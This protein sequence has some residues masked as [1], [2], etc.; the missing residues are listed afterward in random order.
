M[1]VA[2]C[3]GAVP[4]NGTQEP[5]TSAPTES[6]DV[7]IGKQKHP[8]YGRNRRN[9]YRYLPGRG[10]RVREYV[11]TQIMKE[12]QEAYAVEDAADDVEPAADHVAPATDDMAPAVEDATD[13]VTPG[14]EQAAEASD[15][16]AST[17]LPPDN[18]SGSNYCEGCMFEQEYKTSQA[19][20]VGGVGHVPTHTGAT[21]CKWHTP[22]TD[23]SA[24]QAM[25]VASAEEEASIAPVVAAEPTAG[26]TAGASA[27]G[28]AAIVAAESK[29]VPVITADTN[30]SGCNFTVEVKDLQ[31]TI[32]TIRIP[33]GPAWTGLTLRRVYCQINRV[34]LSSTDPSQFRL[35]SHF[36][37]RIIT[38]TMHLNSL[39]WSSHT[40]SRIS[41]M[42]VLSAQ[43]GD[44]DDDSTGGEDDDC[45]Y[46]QEELQD[47][48][49]AYMEDS[50]NFR[51]DSTN[52]ERWDG[53]VD[54]LA[55]KF[56]EVEP[57]ATARAS[58]CF[59]GLSSIVW[60]HLQTIFGMALCVKC[61]TPRSQP[62]S[63]LL[64]RDQRQRKGP[65][66]SWTGRTVPYST[67]SLA[68]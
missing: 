27:E 59:W 40:A 17:I 44:D 25:A 4:C 31:G 3:D 36:G 10:G 34:P 45:T 5:T 48:T 68:C 62:V 26:E 53:L 41:I 9:I 11:Y 57:G 2:G 16:D 54:A 33:C 50:T 30:P 39:R 14:V 24:A 13:D 64:E 19:L 21:G 15:S 42:R 51:S 46:S 22:V 37:G 52:S 49:R 1:F 20:C 18:D 60:Q 66:P 32:T 56:D 61:S 55:E 38:D 29:W 35:Y 8:D 67:P 58:C 7:G 28:E 23:T 63:R 65:R 12:R 47:A 6:L 43:P